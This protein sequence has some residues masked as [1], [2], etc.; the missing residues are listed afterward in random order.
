MYLS[1]IAHS[2]LVLDDQE[3]EKMKQKFEICKRKALQRV[4]DRFGAY[5]LHLAALI[6]DPTV[7]AGDKA[8]LKGYLQ[9]WNQGKI[10][11]GCDITA[12]YIEILKALSNLS[13]ALQVD[14]ALTSSKAFSISSS[15][16]NN[17]MQTLAKQHPKNWP[18]VKVVLGESPKMVTRKSTR[19]QFS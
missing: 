10:L 1:Y 19:V 16:Q 17:A 7:K 3:K 8:Q 6:E 2:L 12:M 13:L 14:Q 4:I 18:T 9:L 5:V 11:V 15:Q